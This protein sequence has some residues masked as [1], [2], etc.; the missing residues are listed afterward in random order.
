MRASIARAMVTRPEI[1]LLDEPFA[2]LDDMLRSKLNDLLL[3]ICGEQECTMLFVTH[4]ISEAI[5]LSHEIA[6]MSRGKIAEQVKVPLEF[7]RSSELR[8]TGRFAEFYG[9]IS[10]ALSRSNRIE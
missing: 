5:Y 6:I 10:D 4:N 3:A 7:P 1:L 9:E 8:R 2:A